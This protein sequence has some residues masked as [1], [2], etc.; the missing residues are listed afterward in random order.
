MSSDTAV[1]YE[2]VLSDLKAKR[3]AIDSAIAAIEAIL[4]QGSSIPVPTIQGPTA[5]IRPDSFFGMSIPEAAKKFLVMSKKPR[6]TQEIAEALLN[7]GMTSASGNFAN[8]VGSVLNR[9]DK[10][11]GEIVRVSRGL[12][13]LAEW[14]PGRKRNFKKVGSDD[15]LEDV[16][17]SGTGKEAS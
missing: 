6:S 3:A 17:E 14:Y 10:S 2:A 12:W 13:G 15:G 11:S 16:V 7:G 9:Q 4:G 8:S 1:N 5:E